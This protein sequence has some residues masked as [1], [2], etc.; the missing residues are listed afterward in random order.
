MAVEVPDDD[1]DPKES[2]DEMNKQHPPSLALE[3]AATIE[4]QRQA[5]ENL[6]RPEGDYLVTAAVGAAW[7]LYDSADRLVG[8]ARHLA[9]G[10]KD[11]ERSPA[12][13]IH[14]E[15]FHLQSIALS[16]QQVVGE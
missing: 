7:S 8:A 3:I 11:D 10:I 13:R 9:Q 16:L 5:R 6:R 12:D 14:D 4:R 1:G 15:T 2:S